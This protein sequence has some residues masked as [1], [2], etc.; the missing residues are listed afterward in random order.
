MMTGNIILKKLKQITDY[1]KRPEISGW[2][3]FTFYWLA[4]DILLV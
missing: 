4:T 2:F 1:K 3:E